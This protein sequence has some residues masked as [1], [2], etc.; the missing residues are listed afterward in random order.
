MMRRILVVDDNETNMNLVVYLLKTHGY[1]AEGFTRGQDALF[2]LRAR[3]YDLALVDILMPGIDGFELARRV[4]AD[5]AIKHVPLVAVTALAM[6]G[7]RERILSSGFDGYIPKPIDPER[8]IDQIEEY[9]G[10]A[11]RSHVNTLV[12]VV[13]DIPVNRQVLRGIL[14]PFGYRITEAAGAP[15][16][17]AHIARE[18]P[19]LILC[20]VHMP[21]G[22]GFDLVERV[23]RSEHWRHIPFIFISSTAWDARDQ[24]RAMELGADKFISRPIDP[25]KVLDEIRSTLGAG[26]G[27]S[28]NR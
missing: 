1:N 21:A 19:D 24:R 18:A 16:A 22:D 23:K 26:H 11:L 27:E 7:D 17:L 2:A 25:Q 13:D 14:A 8:F 15:D 10:A 20:D 9:S 28:L 12:L 5:P 4:R 3:P 6:V